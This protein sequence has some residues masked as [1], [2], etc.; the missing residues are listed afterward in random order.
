MAR[1]AYD[2]LQFCV[3]YQPLNTNSVPY[4]YPVS[5]I[6]DCIQVFYRIN[7]YTTLDLA[8]TYYQIPVNTDDIPKTALTTLFYL[9]GNLF[10]FFV[11]RNAG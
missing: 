6:Q 4:H 9:F 7:I 5:H 11:L 10:S 1:K 3:Y 2:I 8:H